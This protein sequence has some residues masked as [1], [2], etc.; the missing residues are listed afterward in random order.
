MAKKQT[1]GDKVNKVTDGSSNKKYVKLIR[2][3]KVKDKNSLKFSEI[4]LAINGDK[5]PDVAI[6]EFLNK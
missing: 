4:M 3:I 5:N 6:K 1:F 2:A